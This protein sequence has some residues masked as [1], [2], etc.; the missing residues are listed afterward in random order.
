M[1]DLETW[2][3]RVYQADGDRATLDRLYDEW[4]RDYDQQL[5]ASGNPYI[6]IL[7]GFT[8]RFVPD[9]DARILDAGC[10][11][12]NMGLLLQ[13]MGYDNIDGLE[14]AEGMLEMARKK[15]VY[16]NLYPLYLDSTIDL[17][18]AGYDAVIAAGV[19]THG[20]APPQAI[21]GILSLTRP[22][23]VI[24]FSLSQIAWDDHGFRE[25]IEALEQA[26]AWTRLGRSRL[27]RTYPFSE[28]EA[29]LRHWVLAYTRT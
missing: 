29:H 8:G 22:G 15:S 20:H 5:W 14:P 3:E 4:A 11:T 27:F 25:R 10:G 18:A 21:D 1:A 17:P 16:R 28:R 23:G 19:L 26:G 7:L 6:A 9:F 13:Q 24:L 12:G 2:L